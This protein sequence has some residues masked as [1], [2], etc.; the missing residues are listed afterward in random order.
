MAYIELSSA[1]CG[2]V[3][4]LIPVGVWAD[5]MSN[6]LVCSIIC[7]TVQQSVI[8]VGGDEVRPM[9]NH[10]LKLPPIIRQ[11]KGAGE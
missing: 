2:S 10:P 9:G 11:S 1:M 4:Q 7:A 6:S 5:K 3:V 8:P